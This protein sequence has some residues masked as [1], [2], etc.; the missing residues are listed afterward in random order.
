MRPAIEQTVPGPA[1]PA[2]RPAPRAA[3]GDPMRHVF[4]PVAARVRRLRAYALAG[5]LHGRV[6]AARGEARAR[7]IDRAILAGR[8]RLHDGIS[9]LDLAGRFEARKAYLST[10]NL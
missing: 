6:V 1:A 4:E 8:V 10:L 7:F 5:A 9:V 2:P 3:E